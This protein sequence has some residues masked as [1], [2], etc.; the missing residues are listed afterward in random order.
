MIAPW[1]ARSQYALDAEE[2]QRRADRA[3]QH[4][5]E[6][7]AGER[8]AAA[9]DRRAADDDGGDDLELEPDARRCSESG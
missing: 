1:I 2:R 4:D 5:A 3:E 8:A 7:R 6:Q 9:G